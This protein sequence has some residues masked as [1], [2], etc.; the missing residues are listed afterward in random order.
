ML[1][2]RGEVHVCPAMEWGVCAG[3]IDDNQMFDVYANVAREGIVK[4]QQVRKRLPAPAMP[5]FQRSGPVWAGVRGGG[6]G[7]SR[8]CQYAELPLKFI[9]HHSTVLRPRRRMVVQNGARR[10]AA[11][12]AEL[13]GKNRN[14]SVMCVGNVMN[15]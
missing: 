10:V 12:A 5:A 4:A 13:A 6:G 1:P 15:P 11:H 9:M 14:V 2:A 8:P 3:Q 7:V